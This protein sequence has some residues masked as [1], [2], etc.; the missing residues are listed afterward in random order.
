MSKTKNQ[1]AKPAKSSVTGFH[2]K[3]HK[4]KVVMTDKSEFEI[5]TTWG[6]EGDVLRLDADPKNHPAW[7]EN[8]G[9]MLNVNNERV[10]KF[11]NK[12]GNFDFISGAKTESKETA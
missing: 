4:V 5:M 7:Q 1:T 2:P 9:K 12:F 11:N 8:G 3:Q 10:N 6:K